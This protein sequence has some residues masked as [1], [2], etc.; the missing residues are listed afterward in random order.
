MEEDLSHTRPRLQALQDAA[1]WLIENNADDRVASSDIK[2]RLASIV[3][4]FNEL[5]D[6]IND[7]QN[8]LQASLLQ[9]QEFQDSHHNCLD[10][11]AEVEVRMNRFEP[12]SVKYDT[13]WKQDE[14]FKAY[15]VDVSQIQSVY[16]QVL[17]SSKV[18]KDTTEEIDEKKDVENKV[19]ELSK[20]RDV[21]DRKIK[22]RRSD[23]DKLLPVAKD[24]DDSQDDFKP[25]LSSLEEEC[26][27]VKNVPET[28]PECE[29]QL[30]QVK[31]TK[32]K[33]DIAKPKHKDMNTKYDKE[34]LIA[35]K[36]PTVADEPLLEE[37]VS[38]IN[39]RWESLQVTAKE[40]Q[41]Q[42]QKL[43]YVFVK[44]EE[45]VH[46]LEEELLKNESFLDN[47]Q[48]FGLDS[49]EGKKAL[50]EVGDLLRDI[51]KCGRKVDNTNRCGTDLTDQL[52]HYGADPWP[53]NAQIADDVRRFEDVKK[54]L[55]ERKDEVVESVKAV[56]QFLGDLK[57]SEDWL[58]DLTKKQEQLSRISTEPE[59]IKEQLAEVESMLDDIDGR[60][61][62]LQYVEDLGDVVCRNNAD[63][64]SV[65]SEIRFKVTKVKEP[66]DRITIRLVERKTKLENLLVSS[67]K[68]QDTLDD[69]A[70]KLTRIERMHEKMKP[71]SARYSTVKKQQ[72]NTENLLDEVFQL[73]PSFHLLEKTADKVLH[74]TEPNER[75]QLEKK[76]K[77]M[78]TRWEEE[79]ERIKDR[80]N[81]I[82][83]VFPLAQEY[84][85]GE[86]PLAE[87]ITATEKQL[88][89]ITD[90]VL[91]DEK[92]I[93]KE[94]DRLKV[95]YTFFY[96][97]NSKKTLLVDCFYIIVLVTCVFSR[98]KSVF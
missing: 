3:K 5:A 72:I 37:E 11:L 38:D 94:L 79:R 93:G 81:L 43:H 53:I 36:L 10:Q 70:D 20:R 18:V 87:W 74:D 30:N 9:T 33:I 58:N 34:K 24:E 48:P 67:Q 59:V 39:K 35:K 16:E 50:A 47:V 62:N 41:D 77:G 84:D 8:L 4:P 52:E 51:E 95:R 98:E 88:A 27:K 29:K 83:S 42:T 1:A 57:N 28:L 40:K 89:P 54:R 6:K 31:E 60:K 78:K 66:V 73:E 64:F 45:S 22:E 13:L 76:I 17:K 32:A 15:E 44:Y 46:L 21:L 12:L 49:D 2:N 82:D 96:E 23:I 68:L 56:D 19:K 55:H 86:Q 85:E 69:F 92:S 63:D 75:A 14:E 80:R 26:E 91:L 61:P 90:D 65:K 97:L 7:K 71:V 25:I